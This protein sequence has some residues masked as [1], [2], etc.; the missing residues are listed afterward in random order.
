MNK[1]NKECKEFLRKV[2]NR[3]YL[4]KGEYDA[5]CRTLVHKYKEMRGDKAPNE[6]VRNLQ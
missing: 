5:F 3:E 4:Q 1:I 2:S 6:H